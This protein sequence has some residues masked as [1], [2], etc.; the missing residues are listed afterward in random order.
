ME[1]ATVAA[2]LLEGLEARMADPLWLLARQWQTGEFK[3]DDAANPLLMQVEASSVRLQQLVLPG[4]HAVDLAEQDTPLEPLVEREPV[5]SGPA[6]PRVT[7]DLGRLLVRALR[8][9]QATGPFL[10]ELRSR[11][12]VALPPDDGLDPAGRR[13]LELLARASVDGV[14]LESAMAADPALLT[15]I[16][17]QIAAPAPART[18][19]GQVVADWRRMATEVFSEP[20]AFT[21][22]DPQRLEYRFE[23]LGTGVA[24]DQVRLTTGDGYAGGR[25]DWFSFDRA[26]AVGDDS[27]AVTPVVRRAEVLPAPLRFPGMPAGRFWELEEG[28]VYFGGIETAPEDLARVVV[29]GYGTVYGRDWFMLPI[30]VPVGTLTEIAELTVLDDFGGVTQVPAAAVVDGGAPTRGFKFFELSGDPNPLHG[31]APLLFLPP[32]VETT[33]AGRPLEDVAFLRDEMAN[34]AWAVESRVESVTGRAVDVAARGGS[35]PASTAVAAGEA[36]DRWRFVLSTPVPAHWVPLIPVR[37]T[38]AAGSGAT[39]GTIMFQRGRLPVSG[40]PGQ[41]R[42]ARGRI[43]V[44]QH[45]LLIHEEEIPRSGIRVVRRYQSARDAAGRLH[46]WVGRRKGA[47]RGEGDSGLR[48]DVLER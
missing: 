35:P 17:D 46:T 8:R 42:G 47:G 24:G 43:L 14:Q 19:I 10:T 37:L 15:G 45:R 30:R 48:F 18:R 22:W 34:L 7:T 36:D 9:A 25:L 12:P 28:S 39:D 11:F 38:E 5:R 20:D 32:T 31:R 21:T 40:D 1:S 44:P 41:T 3:G 13:R 33:D 23:L 2:D 6:A 16:L 27:P 26:E 29:A 4:G